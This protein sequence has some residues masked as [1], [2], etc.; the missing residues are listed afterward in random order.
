[1]RDRRFAR[2]FAFTKYFRYLKHD[3]ALMIYRLRLEPF[4]GKRYF[5]AE[6]VLK[7]YIVRRVNLN[8]GFNILLRIILI[9]QII[10]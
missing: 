7:A 5:R 3:I 9:V 4:A 2:R 1:M 10:F 8:F 6:I